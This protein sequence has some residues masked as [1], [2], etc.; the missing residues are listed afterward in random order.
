MTPRTTANLHDS[1]VLIFSSLRRQGAVWVQESGHS[2][3]VV[4]CSHTITMMVLNTQGSWSLFGHSPHTVTDLPWLWDQQ[5][6]RLN[7]RLVN[8]IYWH[9]PSTLSRS[10]NKSS[11][12]PNVRTASSLSPSADAAHSRKQK[13]PFRG[14]VRSSNDSWYKMGYLEQSQRS[15]KWASHSM[16]I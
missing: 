9:L 1:L 7:R 8:R 4:L 16:I 15:Q 12:I 3:C 13:M 14:V 10:R 5:L 2:H 6:I 11:G